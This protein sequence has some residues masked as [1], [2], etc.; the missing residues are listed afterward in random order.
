MGSFYWDV[1]LRA[2]RKKMYEKFKNYTEG[3]IIKV[4]GKRPE[5]R[6]TR[7]V[8]TEVCNCS[9]RQKPPCT[10]PEREW[11]HLS[12]L[13]LVA[14][15]SFFFPL[16]LLSMCEACLF[17]CL[18]CGL[19]RNRGWGEATRK[20][21]EKSVE[22]ASHG[23]EGGKQAVG[24]WEAENQWGVKIVHSCPVPKYNRKYRSS[25]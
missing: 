2:S 21:N 24:G 22:S 19:T 18:Q 15:I 11:P 13:N 23:G 20:Q 1:L 7:S 17:I 9:L 16:G 8:I 10:C 6:L 4:W 25:W 14:P 5:I 3:Q 12:S